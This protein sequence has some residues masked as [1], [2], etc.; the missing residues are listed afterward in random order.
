MATQQQEQQPGKLNAPVKKRKRPSQRTLVITTVIIIA[1]AISIIWILSSLGI[2]PRSWATISSIIVT[3]LGVVFAFLQSLHLFFP[4]DTHRSQVASEHAL[5]PLLPQIPPII[6]Q[7]TH[8]GILGLPPP[9]DPKTIQQRQHVVKE[10]YMKLTQPGI[11]AIALTGIGGVGK[12]TLA[13]LIY[14]YAEEQRSSQNSPFLTEALWLTVDPAVTFADLAGNLFEALG[15]PLPALGNLAPQ[16]QAVALFNALNT[17]DKPRLVILDQFENLLD[18]ETGHALTDRPG[19]GEW[20]DIINS[21]SCTCRILLTSRPH[22]VGTREY[23]PTYMQEYPVGGLEVAEGIE[24]LRNLGVHGTEMELRRAA[25]RCAGH[26]FSLTLLASLIRDHSMSLTT[27]FKDPML[28]TGDIATNLLDQI[29]MQRLSEVQRK[30]LLAFS[31]YREPV[32]LN[33][34]QAVITG[35]SR[36]QIS[37]A[38]K[39]L[40]TENL[41]EAHG[42]GRYQLH[43]IIADYAQSH[44]DESSEQANDEALWAAHA[45]AAQ[46]YLQRAAKTCPPR[47]E[48]HR[49][50]DVHDLIEAVWQYSQGGKWEKAFTLMEQEGIFTDL[51]RW[52]S[53][54]ILL[55]LYQLL[56]PLDQWQP[57]RSQISHIYNNLGRVY[58]ALGQKDRAREYHEQ[59]LQIRKEMGDREGEGVTL[60]N[61]GTVY[62]DLGMIKEAQECLEQALSIRR[63]VEDRLG[64]GITLG[65]LG[66]VYYS[67]GDEERAKKYYMEA[68]HVYE[69]VGNNRGKGRTFNNLGRV[70]DDLGDKERA[71]EYYE[72]A[73]RICKET[74]D[75][76]GEGTTINNLGRVYDD[77]GDKERAREYYE[78]ALRICEEVGYHGVEA[79]ALNNLGRAYTMLW[80]LDR[81]REYYEEALRLCKEIGD[82]RVEERTLNNLG[83]VY[84]YQA[85][86]ERALE[87]YE[88]ALRICKE[89]GDREVEETT[90]NNLGVV[91]DDSG[92][93]V[94]A[95]EYYEKALRM[96]RDLGKRQREG[97]I[98]LNMGGLYCDQDDDEIALAS[99]LLAKGI[100]KDIQNQALD[101]TQNYIEMLQRKIGEDEFK[102]LLMRVEP[103]AHQIVERALR[104]G[105]DQ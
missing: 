56:W 9:T 48:R 53:N 71:R 90:L 32:P 91:Y 63:E 50:N 20:L 100:F 51:N 88:E 29:Y 17:T 61:L 47:E 46:Y 19:V 16:N 22:P 105:F 34:A 72:E 57:E 30:L 65:N 31:V 1:L 96:S 67:F 15:K 74:G 26:A 101:A 38:L 10:V 27:L 87:C 102:A 43:A 14:N 28:W 99:F 54:S 40:L 98:L 44:F 49:I 77:L 4:P 36:T 97:K 68:L 60:N 2:I 73:L 81:A 75:R 76:G 58:S 62:R 8:R 39:A 84:Q 85:Q 80:E 82:R 18:W 6:V 92:E 7:P 86:K 89:I 66:V 3:V 33:A 12:S 59:V 25:E 78:E 64:E 23:P 37:P 13:A 11:T 93:K 21:Q 55:N 41:L 52:G 24:L 70:Y 104:K 69:E 79:T 45:M 94:R 42:E 83:V 35:T 95:L 103:E 5:P